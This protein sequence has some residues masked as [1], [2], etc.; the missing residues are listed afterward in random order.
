M[1]QV[2]R[3]RRAE[4]HECAGPMVGQVVANLQADEP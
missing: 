4:L 2:A 3:R 1:T